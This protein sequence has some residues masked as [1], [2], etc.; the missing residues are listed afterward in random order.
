MDFNEKIKDGQLAGK[1]DYKK[2]SSGLDDLGRQLFLQLFQ[3]LVFLFQ[4]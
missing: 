4:K 3:D 2:L 1:Y